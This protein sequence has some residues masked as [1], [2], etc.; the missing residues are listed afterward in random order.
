M[1]GDV[2]GPV[3]TSETERILN[4]WHHESFYSACYNY[5]SLCHARTHAPQIQ[6]QAQQ[7]AQHVV[8]G[9][10]ADRLNQ[11]RLV[12][13]PQLPPIKATSLTTAKLS[14]VG[15]AKI[16]QLRA[17]GITTVEAL[18][19]LQLTAS[20]AIQITGNPANNGKNA[21]KT[22]S[23]WITLA[24]VYMNKKQAQR[25][26]MERRANEASQRATTAQ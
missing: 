6:T 23:G 19:A 8:V 4:N 13:V 2:W 20:H 16:T 10:A 14:G 17:V 15:P 24:N 1:I 9:D 3:G 5:W 22:V 25:A 7:F 26:E 18:A 11:E 21:A 12:A